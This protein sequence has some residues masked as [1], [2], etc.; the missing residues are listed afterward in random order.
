MDIL[1]T[2]L[3]AI[4]GFLLGAVPFSVIIGRLALGKNIQEYGDGNPGAVNVFRAGGHKA[5][6]LAVFLDIAK[7]VPFVFLAHA[8]LGLPDL[9]IVIVAMS[10][11]LG[12]AFSPFLRWHGGKAV[13]ITFGVL[14]GLPQHEA[15]FAFTAFVVAGF[16]LVENDS[17]IVVLG[18]AATLAY[19]AIA[20]EPY[21]IILLLF[22]I[23]VLFV[24]KY[25]DTLHS[26]P[27]LH[28]R[29]IRWLEAK[30]RG[31]TPV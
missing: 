4:A 16:L 24:F 22:C 29:V 10:A 12:H 6:L 11:V 14:M 21:V 2:V 17:W 1:S 7:G 27:R 30:L 23:L 3:L 8:W 9:S 18:A 25:F 13:S 5:G 20:G 26:L 15:F 31:S 19:V 28:G